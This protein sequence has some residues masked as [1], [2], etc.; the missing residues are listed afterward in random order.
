MLIAVCMVMMVDIL[1]L[2]ACC[3]MIGIH[4]VWFRILT[5]ALI[6]GVLMGL[7]LVWSL[8]FS[9]HILWRVCM[10]TVT[11]LVTF[12]FRNSAFRVTLLFLMLHLSLGNLT[13]TGNAML[14]T[15]LGA[16]GIAL[17]CTLVK[18]RSCFVEVSLG[19]Q[20]R[21][22]HF[23][24]LRDTGNEL[25]DPMTGE[26]VLVVSESIARQLTGL[27]GEALAD[28]VQSIT[29]LPGLR[30]IPY[31]TVG[32]TGFL[33]AMRIT[34]AKIGNRQGSVIVAFSPQNLGRNYQGLTGGMLG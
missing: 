21:T 15:V 17:A 23:T 34:D 20:G 8:S 25:R 9:N 28:P 1:L 10:L 22:L 24:A 14:S 11:A 19:Y 3:Q 18:K 13:G 6:D 12:G 30:L 16:T 27:S 32:N 29:L 4:P 2:S 33:L 7:S 31:Q 26:G 5:G